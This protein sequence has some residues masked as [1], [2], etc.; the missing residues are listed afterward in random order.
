MQIVIEPYVDAALKMFIALCA[1]I[2]GVMILFG[3]LLVLVIHRF[4]NC[5][6]AEQANPAP[7]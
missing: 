3:T 6:S 7:T 4:C 1:A 5:S 2:I